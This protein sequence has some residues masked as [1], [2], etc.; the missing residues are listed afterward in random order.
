VPHYR[1]LSKL[2]SSQV[3]PDVCYDQ[4]RE[5]RLHPDLSRANQLLFF[6]RRRADLNLA[7]LVVVCEG[8]CRHLYHLDCGVALL[9]GLGT[10]LLAVASSNAGDVGVEHS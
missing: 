1:L 8:G 6:Q 2:R 7:S 5:W 3:S 10:Q 9:L 4:P